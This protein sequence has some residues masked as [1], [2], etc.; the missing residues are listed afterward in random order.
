MR[1]NGIT[2]EDGTLKKFRELEPGN[3]F[4][5]IN[6]TKIYMK[7]AFDTGERQTAASL[8]KGYLCRLE[9][10]DEVRPLPD[11]ERVTITHRSARG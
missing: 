4:R 2:V 5:R 9:D 8:E 10:S 6:G 3:L 11:G 7:L 1:I